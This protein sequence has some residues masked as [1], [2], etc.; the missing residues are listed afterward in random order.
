MTNVM[1]TICTLTCLVIFGLSAQAAEAPAT[2]KSPSELVTLRIRFGMKDTDNTDWSGTLSLSSGKSES[3]RGWRW[4]PGDK[5]EGNAFTVMTRRQAAQS[6]AERKR[7][8]AGNKLPIKENG[9]IVT[10]SGVTL[11]TQIS[12]DAKPGKASF[13]IAELPVGARLSKLD[14]NLQVERVPVVSPLAES[15]ADEDYPAVATARDGTAYLVYLA[16]TR[17][18]DFQGKRER[19]A[20][21]ESGP[22]VGPLAAGEV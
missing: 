15:A 3:I 14:D 16:F 22:V 7:V 4:M 2:P 6:E 10:L 19:P 13:K 1:R 17:G 5:A 20:T 8:Q 9:I 12:I 18:K 21:V 11:D